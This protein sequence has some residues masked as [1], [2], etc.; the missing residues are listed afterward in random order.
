MDVYLD[1]AGKPRPFELAGLEI[2]DQDRRPSMFGMIAI[3]RVAK[4]VWL[5]GEPMA[6]S[7]ARTSLPSIWERC[8]CEWKQVTLA[9]AVRHFTSRLTPIPPSLEEDI[10]DQDQPGSGPGAKTEN[11]GEEMKPP[12]PE[13]HAPS[14]RGRTPGKVTKIDLAITAVQRR[15]KTGESL[16]FPS[17]AKEAG[18]KEPRTLER[19]KRFM[20]WFPQMINAHKR[21]SKRPYGAI[22]GEAVTWPDDPNLDEQTDEDA[23]DWE[24][25]INERGFSYPD[26]EG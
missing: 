17:I 24:S 6:I 20:R 10:K 15:L 22:D 5:R 11:V 7:S 26:D 23:E 4:G 9:E 3:V 1:L 2:Y 25:R 8:I 16:D 21:L 14:R 19:S 13:M 18:I 12:T